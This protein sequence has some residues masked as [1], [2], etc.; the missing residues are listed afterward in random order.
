MALALYKIDAFKMITLHGHPPRVQQELEVVVRPGVNGVGLWK[1][2]VR[3]RPFSIV[4]IVDVVNLQVGREFYNAYLA[5]IALPNPI[6][7]TWG[8]LDLSAA[9]KTEF[10][11]LGVEILEL[12]VCRTAAGGVSSSSGALLTCRWEMIPVSTEQESSSSL[13]T[14]FAALPAGI[15][16]AFST[17]FG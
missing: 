7:I 9:H 13:F 11:T 2:G 3:G 17:L 8:G 6:K 10:H 12:R 14:N 16:A 1:T 15:K 4:S 5:T